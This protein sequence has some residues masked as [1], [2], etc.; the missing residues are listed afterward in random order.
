[1]KV[2]IFSCV[3]WP[4]VY[5][6][7]RSTIQVL[8]P[9]QNSIVFFIIKLKEFFIYFECQ[10]LFRYVIHRYFYCCVSCLFTFLICGMKVLNFDTVQFNSFFSFVACNFGVIFREAIAWSKV[11]KFYSYAFFF[12]LII[13][14][15]VALDLRCCARAF[16]SCGEWGLLS[17]C[18]AQAPLVGELRLWS[19]GSLVVAPGLSCSEACG[20]F[21]DQESNLCPLHWQAGSFPLCCQVSPLCFLLIF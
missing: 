15:L 13:L 19:V 14:F 2:S 18:G 9:F 20:I 11:M 16:S 17:S 21:P 8:C 10:L 5:L 12:F 3:Y 4:F 1:M 7:W 6:L